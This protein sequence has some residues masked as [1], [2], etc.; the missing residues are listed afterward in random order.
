MNYDPE[1]KIVDAAYNDVSKIELLRLKR[2]RA[3]VRDGA[4]TMTAETQ[5]RLK[6]RSDIFAE[7]IS[8]Y[9]EEIELQLKGYLSLPV[10]P[11]AISFS[12]SLSAD[13]DHEKLHDKI[14]ELK[15]RKD[16]KGREQLKALEHEYYDLQPNLES[17]EDVLFH[18][19]YNFVPEWMDLTWTADVAPADFLRRLHRMIDPLLETEPDG[20]CIALEEMKLQFGWCYQDILDIIRWEFDVRAEFPLL[21]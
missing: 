6:A 21:P 2:E 4:M 11:V 15:H 1:R 16:K 9:M 12:L 7:K 18:D 5:R 13:L 8:R 20:L 14:Q 3:A 17:L 19:D 10:T